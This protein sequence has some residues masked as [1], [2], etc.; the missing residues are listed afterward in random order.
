M[1]AIRHNRPALLV[2]R[3]QVFDY[4]TGW[5]DAA[6][7]RAARDADHPDFPFVAEI[8]LGI[9][10][11][12]ESKCPLKL[13]ALEELFDRVR[14]ML[15][16]IGCTGIAENLRPVA[17]PVTVS[18]LRVAGTAGNGFELAFFEA[19]RAELRELRDAGAEEI[20]FTGLRE[21]AQILSGRDSWNHRCESV[22]REIEQFLRTWEAGATPPGGPRSIAASQ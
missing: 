12:L 3:H 13:L 18:L 22:L 10:E 1:I 6:I 2:G 14:R 17:P 11:Y 9:V 15:R 16:A 8:R 5:L 4:D 7:R 20:H 19:L 21:T